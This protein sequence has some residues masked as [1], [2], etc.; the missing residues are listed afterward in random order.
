[1]VRRLVLLFAAMGL[2]ISLMPARKAFADDFKFSGGFYERLRNEYWK[3]NKDMNTQNM[4]SGDRNFFRFK[5]SIWGQAD[6]ET[7]A[8]LY[9][10]LTNEA[11]SYAYY[12][13][14]A[15]KGLTGDTDEVVFD[16]FYLDIKKP[17]D[18]PVSF[19][20]GRQ[21]LLGMYGENFLIADGT[22]S[23]GSRTFYFNAAKA[24]WTIAPKDTLDV[25]YLNDPKTDQYMPVI[26]KNKGDQA[27]NLSDETGA[28][29]YLKDTS[30]K[31]LNLEPY[32]IYKHEAADGAGLQSQTSMINTY[33]VFSK[34]AMAP[35]TFHVQFAEQTGRY[36]TNA[37][38]AFGGY[39]FIDY[40]MPKVV[41]SPVLTAGAVYLSG[42]DKNTNK[43]EGWDPLFCRYPIWSEIINTAWTGESGA[44]YWSNMA[45]YRAQAALTLCPKAKLTLIYSIL[46]ANELV[47]ASAAY[48]FS[49]TGKNRGNLYQA[50]LDFTINKNVCGYILGELF[51][52]GNFYTQDA[53]N[54][55][56]VRTQLEFKF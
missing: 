18:L 29:V 2:V 52:P 37:R 46:R 31:N 11:K 26:D 44:Y 36:G 15:K 45:M 54:A 34:Y 32:Y 7:L 51:H 6:Y 24:S 8:T 5:T 41:L 12:G 1:M 9:A 40:A 30:V 39:G 55:L 16:N 21:D 19:R 47:P 50:K 10:K 42:D 25:I 53:D 49:G 4:D 20:L 43:N 33:G 35:W 3:N 48:D 17:A 28:I 14:N 38:Q 23:D 22:G 56:F 13:G 27:L